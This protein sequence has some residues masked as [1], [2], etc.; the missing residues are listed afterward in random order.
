MPLVPR[1][2]ASTAL[3]G[4]SP[5]NS[6]M[7]ILAPLAAT[8]GAP[9]VLHALAPGPAGG[10]ESVVR[11]LA[12]EW[13]RQGGEVGVALTLDAGC[14]VP[15]EFAALREA[16]V[17]VLV[18]EVKPRGYLRERALQLD[19]LRAFRP[20]IVHSHGYRADL[21]AGSAAGHLRVA[22]VSTVHGFTGGDWKNRL[23]ESLQLRFL[24]GFDAVIAVSRPLV[25]RLAQTGIPV[26]RIVQIPNAWG[27]TG[28]ALPRA[29]ARA[30]LGLPAEGVLLGWVGR[31]SREKGP[32]IF[33]R[34]LALPAAG[35]AQAVIIGEGGMREELLAQT[36][37]LGVSDRVHWAGLVPRAGRLLA[38]F[39]G[40]VLSSRTEGTPIALFEAMAAGVP[41]VATGVGGVPDV[42]EGGVA[43]VVPPAD[44]GALAEGIGLLLA[45]P[46]EAR[47]RAARAGRR[48]TDAYALD[49]WLAR[50]RELYTSILARR[51]KATAPR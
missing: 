22:R 44:P 24:R 42:L 18:H 17:A 12:E 5:S 15:E 28:P 31:L 13:A 3:A 38:A 21:L 40:F 37:A 25:A 48:L 35:R 49:P 36:V 2:S 33:L 23:Y 9:R 26:D 19:T 34:A 10:L 43:L 46:A 30:A 6:P 11:M 4:A 51:G 39:D 45:D 16:G 50:H 7:A 27:P 1:A 32:D 41:I 14:D 20:D 29:A 8:R 47:A